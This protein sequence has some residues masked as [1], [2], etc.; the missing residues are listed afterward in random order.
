MA[1]KTENNGII[2]FPD[3]QALKD[4]VERM[5]TELSMLLSER[6]ELQF[7]VAKNIN[8]RY[9]LELGSLEYKAYKAQCAALRL[10]RKIELIQALKNRQAPVVMAN[11]E[12]TLD[13]EFAAYQQKLEEQMEKMN[14][15]IERSQCREL[16]S[17]ENREFKKLYREVVKLLHPDLNPDASEAQIKLFENAVQAYRSGDLGTLRMIHEMIAGQQSMDDAGQDT[18]SILRKQ[19]EELAGMIAAVRES[20]ARIKAE[21]PFTVLEILNDSEKLSERR[22]EL[23]YIMDYYNELIQFYAAKLQETLR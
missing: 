19:R 18:W 20:I 7:V 12:E 21:Y 5:K 9:M 4:E 8:A 13:A 1:T 3:F 2:L 17:E 10:K 6:D 23:E 15:A 22:K 11:V 14:E 16:S